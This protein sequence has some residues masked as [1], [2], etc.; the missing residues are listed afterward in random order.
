MN[1]QSGCHVPRSLCVVTV[2]LTRTRL[3]APHCPR[4]SSPTITPRTNRWNTPPYISSSLPG[5]IGKEFFYPPQNPHRLLATMSSP[6]RRRLMR[7]FKV[8]DNPEEILRY[9]I[10]SAFEEILAS[11][12]LKSLADRKY[13]SACKPTP[14]L[15][16][17]LLPSPTMS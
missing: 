17:P 9:E 8:C 16:Y 11:I 14:P 3:H 1:R 15:E 5:F 7:D 4:H 13:H 6:A 10:A 2:Y 12:S